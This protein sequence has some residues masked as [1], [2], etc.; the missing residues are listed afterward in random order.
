MKK[1]LLLSLLVF[2]GIQVNAQ[3]LVDLVKDVVDKEE[4]SD[5]TDS[6]DKKMKSYEDVITDKAVTSSGL[7]KIHKVE[8]VYYLDVASAIK[9]EN[10][11]LP[12]DSNGDGMHFG[13]TY[14]NKWFDY[15]KTHTVTEEEQP[16]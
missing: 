1:T 7:M 5:T 2:L 3:S 6:K 11:C 15:L 4:K 8:D 16:S 9:D 14:Y 10:G 12:E 13:T